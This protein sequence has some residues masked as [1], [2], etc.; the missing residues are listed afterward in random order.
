MKGVILPQI[1]QNLRCVLAGNLRSNDFQ[2][3]ESWFG[4]INYKGVSDQLILIGSPLSLCMTVYLYGKDKHTQ[5]IHEY[6]YIYTY[7]YICIYIYTSYRYIY[8]TH[9]HYTYLHVHEKHKNTIYMDLGKKTLYVMHHCCPL[10]TSNRI[11]PSRELVVQ[12]MS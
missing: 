6:I 1:C 5:H 9:T 12:V 2:P 8:I 10:G 7:I 11:H 3:P 4:C